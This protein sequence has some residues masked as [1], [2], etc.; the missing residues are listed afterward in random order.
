[1]ETFY[2]VQN[3]DNLGWYVIFE[4]EFYNH[5]FESHQAALQWLRQQCTVSDCF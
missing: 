5:P 1:M 3:T 4:K 2:I